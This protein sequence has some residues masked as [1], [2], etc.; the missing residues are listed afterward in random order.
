MIPWPN[1]FGH[2]PPE[3]AGCAQ[4][5]RAVPDRPASAQGDL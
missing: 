4:R 1:H 2:C 3:G 5:F